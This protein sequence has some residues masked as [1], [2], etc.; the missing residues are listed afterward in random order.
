LP[1]LLGRQDIQELEPRQLA[2]AVTG[3]AIDPVV[4]AAAVFSSGDLKKFVY[5]LFRP[6][7]A[8]AP[9]GGDEVEGGLP[10][11]A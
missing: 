8:G 6:A 4:V 7:G 1:K 9:G 11:N 5:P 10:K 3:V 2:L